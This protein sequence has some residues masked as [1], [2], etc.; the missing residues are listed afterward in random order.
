MDRSQRTM[1][2]NPWGWAVLA[3]TLLALVTVPWLTHNRL[4]ARDEGVRSAWATLQSTLQR[5]ADLIPALV[6]SV[7]RYMAYESETLGALS[8][9]RAE[10][11]QRAV[12]KPP[13]DTGALAKIA[14]LDARVASDARSLIAIADSHPRLRAADHFLALQAQ[15]EGTENRI[16]IA[17]IRYN[18]AVR[19]HNS[20]IR[21]YLGRYL[22][23]TLE[24]APRPYFEAD[25]GVTDAVSLE[26]Q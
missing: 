23:T 10:A 4:M 13:R 6:Q 9:R 16:N 3:L 19:E 8:A 11:L 2:Q 12:S 26:F 24:M 5:R 25:S 1:H 17:R 18:R 15:L 20:A 22:A 21:G 7:N 14:P